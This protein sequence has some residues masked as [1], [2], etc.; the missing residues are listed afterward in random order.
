MNEREARAQA[1]RGDPWQGLRRYT[2]ARIALGRCGVSLPTAHHLQFQ[3]AHA[4]ARDAVHLPFEPQELERQ[5]VELGLDT[6]QLHSAA[7]DRLQYL[8]RP[9]L[10]RQLEADSAQ[11]LRQ[12]ARAGSCCYDLA[13]VVADGLSALAVHQ[14]AGALIGAFLPLARA[15]GWRLAPVALVTQ[16]RVGVGDE[17]GALLGARVV[18]ILIGERPGLSSP[19]SL[20]VYLTHAPAPGTTDERRNCVSNIRPAGLL[21]AIAAQKLCYLVAEALRRQLSGVQLKDE[22]SLVE[23]GGK[24]EALLARSEATAAVGAGRSDGRQSV[25]HGEES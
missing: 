6:L 19:D 1:L 10:G 3:L 24:M 23:L 13:L 7:A 22:L 25:E 17:I 2:A 16:G 15:Q 9:D 8:Q 5:L 20:G 18:A 11:R 21:P 14:H 12:G 4:R